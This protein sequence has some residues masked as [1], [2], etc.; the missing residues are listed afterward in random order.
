MTDEYIPEPITVFEAINRVVTDVGNVGRDGYN[1]HQRFSFRSL[2]GTVNAV[3]DSLIQHG[4]TIV[5]SYRSVEQTD[6]PAAPDRPVQHRS[7]V[8]GEFLITGPD[9]SDVTVTT[10]GEAMDTQGRATNKAMSAAFKYAL[11]QTFK[12]ASGDDGD[13]TDTGHA[14]FATPQ[15]VVNQVRGAQGPPRISA[16]PQSPAAQV[17][18]RAAQAAP[19]GRQDAGELLSQGQK[20][21][22]WRLFKKLE[23]QA[24]WT[25]NDYKDQI[26]LVSG[27]R[28]DRQITK[29]QASTLIR[30]LKDFAGE[31]DTPAPTYAGAAAPPAEDYAYGEEPF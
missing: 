14:N 6:L 23:E 25:L 13:A 28:D 22:C 17:A 27:V 5:P 19:P 8:E 4:I 20:S 21:N 16:P 30:T 9:G 31:E 1:E 10:I 7:I 29:D 3:R 26:E 2:E 12:I 18:A 15:P 24:G 11:L